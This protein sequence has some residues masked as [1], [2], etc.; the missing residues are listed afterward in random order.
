[1]STPFTRAMQ[2]YC[3]RATSADSAM[4][5][6]YS[7]PKCCGGNLRGHPARHYHPH[8]IFCPLRPVPQRRVP[9]HHPLSRGTATLPGRRTHAMAR[10]A[11]L[12][13]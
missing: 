7:F 5:S 4:A 8:T 3:S 1:M 13:P 12:P 2:G 9:R 11:A 10:K 6:P